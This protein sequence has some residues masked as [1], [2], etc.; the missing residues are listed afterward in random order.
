MSTKRAL[1]TITFYVYGESK[2]DFEKQQYI[3]AKNVCD[4]LND[5]YD[6]RAK[7]QSLHKSEFGVIDD[8]EEI[9]IENFK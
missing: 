3:E 4:L 7:L 8:L 9:N 6:C 1:A 2:E 5:R